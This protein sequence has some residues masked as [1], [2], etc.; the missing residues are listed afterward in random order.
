M[1]RSQVDMNLRDLEYLIAL[2]EH[3]HFGRAAEACFVSQPTLSVQIQKLEDEL[4]VQLVERSR[5]QILL[6]ETG[7][8]IL[9]RA[10]N[11]LNEAEQIRYIARE[12]RDPASGSLR[13][14][15]FHT[16]GAYLLP[17][18]IG[19]LHQQLPKL[20]LLLTEEKTL[21]LLELM[22][23]GE[24]DAALLAEPVNDASLHVEFLFAEPFVLAMPAGHPM[25]GKSGFHL[26]DLKDQKLLLLE[27]GHCLRDQALEICHASGASEMRGFRATSLEMV[28]QMVAAEVGITLLPILAVQPPVACTPDIAL[29][30]FDN[31]HPPHRRIALV[32]RKTSA[33]HDFLLQIAELFRAL[34][35]R[36]L[37][38]GTLPKAA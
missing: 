11:L 6:T 4:G 20:E 30:A 8:K 34:P 26:A 3:G 17:H 32:W 7:K 19:P 29:R 35:T 9:E 21:T 2:A 25:A 10:H 5:R 1:G 14:G 28:R 23:H 12:A 31:H 36:L 38:P 16:L 27:D 18:V 13:L 37:D 24:L 22:R 33:M 15:V